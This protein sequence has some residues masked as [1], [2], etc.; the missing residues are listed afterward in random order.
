M[1]TLRDVKRTGITLVRVLLLFVGIF[2]ASY[3]V[4]HLE[5]QHHAQAV[6]IPR[7]RAAMVKIAT[8]SSMGGI[9]VGVSWGGS[10][11]SLTLTFP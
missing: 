11:S 1:T 7:E 3:A 6:L 2:A 5:H 4:A 10:N 9:S 8:Q